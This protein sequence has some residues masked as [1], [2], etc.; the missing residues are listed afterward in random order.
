MLYRSQLH[1]VI[2]SLSEANM[3][4]QIVNTRRKILSQVICSILVESG[5]DA[6]DKQVVETLTEML[7]SCETQIWIFTCLI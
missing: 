2:P 6:C 4:I 5:Y 3:E 1:K 7:Q